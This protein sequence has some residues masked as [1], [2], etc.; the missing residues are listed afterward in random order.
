MKSQKTFACVTGCDLHFLVGTRA[1]LTTARHFHPEVK[2][3]CFTHSDQVQEIQGALSD[4][5]HVLQIPRTLT[6][7]PAKWMPSYARLFIP[8]IIRE[9]VAAWVDSDAIF[10]GRAD[11]L[12]DVAPNTVNV[13][14]DLYNHI[15]GMVRAEGWSRYVTIFPQFNPNDLG[16]N[17]GVFALRPTDWPNLVQ[18]FELAYANLSFDTIPFYADQLILNG[19]FRAEARY[20]SNQYNAHAFLEPS[21][22]LPRDVRIIHYAS[23]PKPWQA[24]YPKATWPFYYWEKYAILCNS[25]Q[26]AFAQIQIYLNYPLQWSRRLLRKFRYLI[27]RLIV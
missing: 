5:A 2:R 22:G 10:I 14:A 18:T 1:L 15:Y 13:T 25:N 12:W 19:I 24:S 8:E 3:Y 7:V 17:A 6:G 27:S 16:F 11:Q 20:L 4:L 23:S 21:I 9:D 26:L